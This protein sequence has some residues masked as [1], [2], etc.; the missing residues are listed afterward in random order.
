VIAAGFLNAAKLSVKSITEQRLVF[1]FGAG[2][3]GIGVADAIVNVMVESSPGLTHEHARQKFWFIDS[4]GLVTS[5][6]GDKLEAHKIPYA[7]NDNGNNQFKNLMDIIEFVKPT[8]LIGL[9]GVDGG[10]FTAEA[11]KRMA[12]I[13]ERPIIFALSNPTKKSECTAE[14]AYR[15]TNGKC[16]FASGSP[17]DN[18]QIEGKTYTPSQG[19]NMYIFS[20][21]GFGAVVA[22]AKEVTDGMLMQSAKTLA[23]SV[24]HEELA[25]GR[26][27]PKLDRMRDVSAII[28]ASVAD[29]ALS[30]GVAKIEAPGNTLQFVKDSM[31]DPDYLPLASNY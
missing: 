27:Y 21:L 30:E 11:L 28:A 29:K 22:N 18:V 10:Y 19:N 15:N 8:T 4:R 20:G 9:A 16:I 2:S 1:F 7:R 23:D 26:L 3:A 17:F 25:E 6:R 24:T 5:N 31:F 12:E 13:N 14:E